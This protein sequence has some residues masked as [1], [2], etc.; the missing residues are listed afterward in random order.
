MKLDISR[1]VIAGTGSGCGK[2]V[3][4]A[5]IL[6]CLTNRGIKTAAFKCGPD[7]IDP[8]F[9]SR[10][11][12][13]RCGNLDSYFA[14]A[15]LLRYVLQNGSAGCDISVIEGVMGYFDGIGFTPRS[16]T[17]ETALKLKAPTV[18]VIDARGMGASSAA[19]LDG[20]LH[21]VPEGFE[22]GQADN[23]IA[24]VIFNN[25]SEKLYMQAE[26]SVSGRGIRPLGYVPV[27]SSLKL[28]SR[29]LGLV[30]ADEVKKLNDR[31]EQ[32]ALLM[33]ETLDIDGIIELAG[34][35][36][37]IDFDEPAAVRIA[38]RA[39]DGD[40]YA[41]AKQIRT[42][43]GATRSAD[44][45]SGN[46]VIIAV[47]SDEAFCFTYKE[48]L[49]FLKSCGCEIEYFSP[50]HDRK[51]PEGTA[52][53]ILSGGYP[54][55]YARELSE[56]ESMLCEIRQAFK[57][58][59]PVIAE[60]GGFMYLH[61]SLEDADG[62]AYGMA[63]VIRGRCFKT[64]R[65]VRFGYIELIANR[66]GLLGNKGLSMKAHEFHYWT[67]SDPGGDFK[68]VK[69]DGSR[70]WSCGVMTENVYAGFPHLFFYESAEAAARFV[71]RCRLRS[72]LGK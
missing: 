61:E 40:C 23:G 29:H 50:V 62:K 47:A 70:S 67:S 55:L 58:G 36:P 27:S 15:D 45:A 12:G 43:A 9:H 57:K 64:D 72:R 69:P 34:E 14:S 59:Y 17:F 20:F 31:L 32:A 33:E 24:G 19:V 52:G 46:S 51:L 65:L 1:I 42:A 21:Y 56:N 41:D 30:K 11:A 8:M 63:G 49:E 4:A 7:Y 68:A 60:C 37:A 44:G 13:T 39:S 25:M 16:S 22:S 26:G 18:L 6:R 5:G 3:I 53:I 2:T 48:N 66:D 10:A 54:E 35:A 28:E 71:K 38:A